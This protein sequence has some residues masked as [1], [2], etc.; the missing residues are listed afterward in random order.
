[1]WLAPTAAQ[2]EAAVREVEDTLPAYA[3]GGQVLSSAGSYGGDVQFVAMA[4]VIGRATATYS[5]DARGGDGAHAITLSM[6]DGGGS[7]RRVDVEEALRTCLVARAGVG[8]AVNVNGNHWHAMIPTALDGR[9][10]TARV[11]PALEAL[12]DGVEA[13]DAEAWVRRHK[14][15]A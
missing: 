3:P 7:L 4:N 14:V 9:A 13:R 2:A 1:M 11:P 8:V 6:P 10:R 5:A 12:L 15:H